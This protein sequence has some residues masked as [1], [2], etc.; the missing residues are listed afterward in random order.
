MTPPGGGA[1]PS[2]LLV[3]C[4]TDRRRFGLSLDALVDRAAHAARGGA[5]A[6]QIRERDLPDRDLVALVRRIGDACAGTPARLLVNDRFDIAAVSGAAGVHLRADSPPASRVAAFAAA[7][8]SAP[9]AH[10]RFIIGRSVHTLEEIDAAIA[11]GACNYLLFGTVFPST[12]KP[13][14]HPVAG[15]EALRAACARSPLPV[16]AIGGVDRS[17]LQA[18][19]DAGAAG[20][21]AVEMFMGLTPFPEVV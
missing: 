4:V 21:A 7:A 10:D 17:R 12:G 1:L 19:A 15:L 6:I 13:A 9:G 2:R 3:H 18:I 20:Y 5:D 8:A 11:D 16:I 14:G